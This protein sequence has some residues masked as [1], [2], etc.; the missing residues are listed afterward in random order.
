MRSIIFTSLL[1]MASTVPA[2]AADDLREGCYLRDYSDAHLAKNPHQIVK[3]IRMKVHR[4]SYDDKVV[5]LDVFLADQG[6]VAQS[7][8]GGQVLDQTLHCW[9]SDA[10]T[11][12]GVDCD[13]G[14][15]RVLRNDDNSLL[16][17]TEYLMVGDTESCGGAVDLAEVQGQ[18]V[19]YLLNRVDPDYCEGN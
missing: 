18:P 12:C 2:L 6:H 15:F 13:G 14:S 7:G 8:H 9:Q 16:V 10:R 4:D 11:G 3:W 17:E 5:D 1:V 19:R